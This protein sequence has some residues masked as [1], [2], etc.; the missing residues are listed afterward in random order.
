M[1]HQHHRTKGI[2]LERLESIIVVDLFRGLLWEKNS[3]NAQA[4]VKVVPFDREQIVGFLL[5]INNGLL[6]LES[7]S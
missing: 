2:D 3:R 1:L 5:G 4:E 7:I 6:V